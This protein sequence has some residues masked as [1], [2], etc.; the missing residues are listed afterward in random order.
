MLKLNYLDSPEL[1]HRMGIHFYRS[2]VE[3]KDNKIVGMQID[4]HNP[5]TMTQLDFL[6][7]IDTFYEVGSYTIMFKSF[8]Q[9]KREA[10]LL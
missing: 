5:L 1:L 10:Q 6:Y 2:Q 4:L 9:H 3:R 7:A 8:S